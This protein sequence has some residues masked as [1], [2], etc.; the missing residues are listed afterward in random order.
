MVP[1]KEEENSQSSVSTPD[2]ISQD[3]P[4]AS[5][6]EPAVP[7]DDSSTATGDLPANN[8][9]KFGKFRILHSSSPSSSSGEQPSEWASK[10]EAVSTP[11]VAETEEIVIESAME[12]EIAPEPIEED[13]VVEEETVV[14]LVEEE[15][16]IEPVEEQVMEVVHE[17]LVQEEVV[18]KEEEVDDIKEEV[19]IAMENESP[20]PAVVEEKE[21]DQ[22]PETPDEETKDEVHSPEDPEE[23]M[24]EEVSENLEPADFEKLSI[25]TETE[26]RA[27]VEPKVKRLIYK[28]VLF[29]YEF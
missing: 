27:A 8:S 6:P 13:T 16:I 14:E 1:V 23:E 21:E 3:V 24:K 10:V 29:F 28:K 4:P 5:S 9:K 17:E 20:D 7:S 2:D 22:S 19:E 15:S 18:N 25:K 26:K 12:V 11:P